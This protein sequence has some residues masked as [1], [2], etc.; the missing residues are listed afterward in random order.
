MQLY[1]FHIRK[2]TVK[3]FFFII[4]HK[5]RIKAKSSS[6]INRSLTLLGDLPRMKFW[7]EFTTM[8]FY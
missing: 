8:K 1:Y 7:V 4:T 5:L 6:Y 2:Q 3:D